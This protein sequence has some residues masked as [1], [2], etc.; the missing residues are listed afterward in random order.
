[1]CL[2]IAAWKSHPKFP[3]IIAANRDEFFQRP[4][5]PAHFWKDSP[6]V[7]GGRDM[8]KGGTW[9]GVNR[10]G[11]L[12]AV[13]NYRG[14]DL[15]A[16]GRSRGE[17]VAR[18]LLSD[19]PCEVFLKQISKEQSLYNPFN[20]LLFD[21]EQLAFTADNNPQK[22][23]LDPGIHVIGNSRID[24]DER[25]VDVARAA[26][27]RCLHKSPTPERLIELLGDSEPTLSSDDKRE[28]ALSAFFVDLR[29]HGYGTRATTV[30]LFDTLGN[31][32]F[33]EQPFDEQGKPG[34]AVD[35]AFNRFDLAA[36]ENA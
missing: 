31:I 34:R 21:G 20:L 25:K 9:L 8:E 11:H 30:V 36:A 23:L 15:P 13:T 19:T 29:E 35:I 6:S 33:F 5:I 17:L 14:G 16:N 32:R 7:L 12:A 26:M 28:Q 2:I 22:K 24:A 10:H 18:Y 3:L 27:A 1:M 4:S